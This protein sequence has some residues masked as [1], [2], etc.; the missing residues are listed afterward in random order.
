MAKTAVLRYR[1]LRSNLVQLPL[2]VYAG[3]VQQQVVSSASCAEAGPLRFGR[4]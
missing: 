3:L 1:S 2:S 4:S